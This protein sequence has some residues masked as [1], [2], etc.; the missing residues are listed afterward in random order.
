MIT[1]YTSPACIQCTMTKKALDRAGIAYREIDVQ[2]DTTAADQL[3]AAG[4]QALPVIDA[5][6]AGTWTGFQPDKIQQLA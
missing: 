3:R 6:N 5:G 4:H 2:A 1:V